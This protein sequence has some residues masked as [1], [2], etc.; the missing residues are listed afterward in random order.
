MADEKTGEKKSAEP[1]AEIDGAPMG[2]VKGGTG[3]TAS[4]QLYER[5][6]Q[7]AEQRRD[8]ADAEKKVASVPIEKGGGQM[9]VS[10]MTQHPEIPKAYIPLTYVNHHGEPIIAN[11]QEVM[12]QADL[13]IGMDPTRPMELTLI[14]VCPRCAKRGHKHL[15]DCQLTIRQSNKYF[16]FKA[17][18]GPPTF[19]HEGKTFKSAGMIVESEPF[20]CSDCDWRARI[21]KNRV[22]PD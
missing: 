13:I 4:E 18:M 22:W 10:Q 19:V 7:E 2:F 17:G 8:E 6:Y 20:T 3:T 16:E 14:I 1:P 5:R 9:H 12:C 11:G 21:S 15:Q